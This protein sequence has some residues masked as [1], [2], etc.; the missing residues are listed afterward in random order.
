MSTG[1]PSKVNKHSTVSDNPVIDHFKATNSV[2][3][4]PLNAN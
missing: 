1:G 2:L 3:G 4:R